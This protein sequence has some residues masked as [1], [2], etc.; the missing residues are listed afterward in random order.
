[1]FQPFV[2][3]IMNIKFNRRLEETPTPDICIAHAM[4]ILAIRGERRQHTE[5]NVTHNLD[6]WHYTINALGGQRSAHCISAQDGN[7]LS[8]KPSGLNPKKV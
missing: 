5:Q 3:K 8:C 2:P 6:G 7:P 4:L 1:M